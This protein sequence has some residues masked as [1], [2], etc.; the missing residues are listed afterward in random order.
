M[1]RDPLFPSVG[2][3]PDGQ[4]LLSAVREL[5]QRL[6]SGE[7]MRRLDTAQP[8]GL[9][10]GLAFVPSWGKL[11]RV[12][13]PYNGVVLLPVMRPET[14]GVPLFV[15]KTSATG[16]MKVATTGPLVNGY[17]GLTRSAAGLMTFVPDGQNWW[18]Q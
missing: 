16:V 17:S 13:E 10:T 3:T 18:A 6:F 8:F 7:F 1:S 14:I 4:R 11:N 12:R 5:A 9:P 2:A 15:T